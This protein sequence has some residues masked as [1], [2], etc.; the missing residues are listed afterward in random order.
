M[1]ITLKIEGMSCPH[2][3]KHVSDALNAL[4][5]VTAEVNLQNNA[6]YITS[7]NPINTEELVKVVEDAGYQV[8]GI[9]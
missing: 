5:G 2:C 1:M 8:T 6:A 9:E 7:D 3:Q 4:S